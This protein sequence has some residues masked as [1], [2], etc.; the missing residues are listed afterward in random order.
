MSRTSLNGPDPEL[1]RCSC[2]MCLMRAKQA[3]FEDSKN[4]LEKIWKDSKSD[5]ETV[6]LGFDPKYDKMLRPGPYR[7]VPGD[8]PSLGIIGP[9]T[10]GGEDGLCWDHLAGLPDPGAPRLS[11]SALFKPGGGLR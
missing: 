5:A 1:A 11:S 2:V 4:E 6:Y 8:A 7:G 9:S 3:Q 10:P